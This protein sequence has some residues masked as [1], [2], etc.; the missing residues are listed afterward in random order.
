MKPNKHGNYYP[1]QQQS[2]ASKLH[3][4]TQLLSGFFVPFHQFNSSLPLT[5][6]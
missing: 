5:I 3:A 1:Q 6:T 2:K 4:Q